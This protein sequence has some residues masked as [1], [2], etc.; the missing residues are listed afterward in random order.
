MRRSVSIW[1]IQLGQAYGPEFSVAWQLLYRGTG[2]L[3]FFSFWSLAAQ[4]NGL[5]GPAGVSPSSIPF[6]ILQISLLSGALSGLLMF[7]GRWPFFSALVALI[8]RLWM[9]SFA[10]EWFLLEGDAW[11]TLFAMVAW[12]GSSPFCASL[13]AHDLTP[14]AVPALICLQVSVGV[15]L[16]L[17]GVARLTGAEQAWQDQTVLYYLF[18]QMPFPL[19]GSWYAHYLPEAFLQALVV[20]ILFVELV[21][22]FYVLLP[23]VFRNLCAGALL[24]Y[25]LG[26]A[27]V[28]QP[29]WQPHLLILLAGTLLDNRSWRRILP[30]AFRPPAVSRARIPP[31]TW[32]GASQFLPFVILLLPWISG[33]PGCFPS[34]KNERD[35][36]PRRRMEL[37]FQL[38]ADGQKWHEV[39]FKQKAS[40]PWILHSLPGLHWS[41]LDLR[42]QK[43]AAQGVQDPLWQREPWVTRLGEGLLRQDPRILNLMERSEGL[44]Q[45]PQMLR[46]LWV[47]YRFTDPVSKRDGGGWWL[48]E[49]IGQA[50]PM[51]R[52]VVSVSSAQAS[53]PD[54]VDRRALTGSSDP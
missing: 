34:W 45:P 52:A 46:V 28:G 48:R 29:G 12:L 39:L 13:A 50:A 10:S 38:S 47:E 54:P 15:R 43:L 41:R 23:R 3:L 19:Q 16:F 6:G 1:L 42:L 32:K 2:L 35:P 49:P 7:F 8:L 40:N 31:I 37:V 24:L 27:L 26:F 20:G 9:M 5:L 18:E 4:A 14:R 30:D 33:F 22:P 36:V 53:S 11:L 44:K 51:M 25:G 17:T 21:G